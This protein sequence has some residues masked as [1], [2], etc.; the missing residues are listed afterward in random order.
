MS[1][2]SVEEFQGMREIG[3]IVALARDAMSHRLRPGVTT[4]ELDAVGEAVLRQNG[5]R[6]APQLCYGFP[7]ATCISVND[8]A[9]H[10]IPGPRRIGPG[11][12]VNIDVSAEKGGFFADTGASYPMPGASAATHR[13]CTTVRSAWHAAASTLLPQGRIR[14]SGRQVEAVARRSGYRAIRNLCAHGIGRWLHEA[15]L[16]IANAYD[17]SD[18]RRFTEGLVVAMEV[19][20]AEGASWVQEA[21]DG[22][23]LRTANGRRAAQHEHTVVVTNGEP[24]VLTEG[25]AVVA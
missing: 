1:I 11:D 10:G 16:E 20:L 18:R 9:A 23:T 19:F 5:A 13:L 24:L 25:E 14:E 21:P 12:V 6:S 15:P 3:R 2:T 7:G 8:E 22:W 17:R 4:A